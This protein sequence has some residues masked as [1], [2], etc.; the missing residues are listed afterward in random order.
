MLCKTKN[1]GNENYWKKWKM[2]NAR[3][4]QKS[5]RWRWAENFFFFFFFWKFFFYSVERV[6]EN[7]KTTSGFRAQNARGFQEF[8]K[9]KWKIESRIK[10]ITRRKK[11]FAIGK[12]SSKRGKCK[13]KKKKKFLTNWTI[14][15]WKKMKKREQKNINI[16]I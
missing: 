13:V 11:T 3:L 9:I 1:E 10:Q 4:K 5:E 2:Q 6:V 12:F 8:S 16:K 14:S 7:Q 15:E